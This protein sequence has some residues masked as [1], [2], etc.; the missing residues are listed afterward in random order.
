MYSMTP[1]GNVRV[2]CTV[3]AYLDQEE[4]NP[5]GGEPPGQLDI[6]VLG[7]DLRDPHQALVLSKDL[8]LHVLHLHEGQRQELFQ[9]EEKGEKA[10]NKDIYTEE[11]AKVVA[12]S[13]VTELLKEYI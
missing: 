8:L 5:E 4:V 11:K 2:R 13:W 9:A 3:V 12:A 10:Y 1:K 7:I 6:L